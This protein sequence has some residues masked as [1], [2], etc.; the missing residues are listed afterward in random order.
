M[1]VGIF[2]VHVCQCVRTCTSQSRKGRSCSSQR[3][4]TVVMPNGQYVMVRCDIKSKARDVFDMVVAHANLVEHFY[5]GLAFLDGKG[6]NVLIVHQNNRSH[7]FSTGMKFGPCQQEERELE[8]FSLYLCHSADD[9][10]F[11]L[12][13]ESKV[14]KAAPDSWKKGQITSFLVFLRVKFFVDDVSLILWVHTV[15][16]VVFVFSYPEISFP[17]LIW[18]LL[19]FSW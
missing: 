15:L 12:D 17:F 9:E 6:H 16:S 2:Y 10:Y 14:S 8:R 1:Y 4:V 13:P 19:Y 18:Q 3:E 7:A 5:F 11:F